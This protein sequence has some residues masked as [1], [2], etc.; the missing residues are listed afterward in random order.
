MIKGAL[1][2]LT[3][4]LAESRHAQ[5]IKAMKLLMKNSFMNK[6]PRLVWSALGNEQRTLP[7]PPLKLNFV[8]PSEINFAFMAQSCCLY[9]PTTRRPA[10]NDPNICAKIYWG[11]FRH[12]NPFQMAKHMVMAGLKWPPDV[13]AQAIM[14]KAIPMANAKPIWNIEPKLDS[15]SGNR[16]SRYSVR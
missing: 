16:G 15:L 10:M 6:S 9:C 12:G 13:G 7:G 11:T 3:N 8:T 5:M 4:G 14:A 2:G 1:V